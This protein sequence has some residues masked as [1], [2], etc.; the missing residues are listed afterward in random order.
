MSGQQTGDPAKLADALMQLIAKD[1]RPFR[2]PAGADAVETFQKK[3]QGLIDQAN[4]YRELS[5]SLAIDEE[6]RT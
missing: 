1:D 2:W 4:A 5:S 6:K 3:G